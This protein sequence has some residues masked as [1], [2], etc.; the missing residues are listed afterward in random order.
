MAFGTANVLT[1]YGK[2]VSATQVAGTTSTPPKY[3]AIGTGATSAARTAAVGD[4]GLSTEYTAVAR[5]TGVASTVTTLQTNDTFQTVGTI[6]VAGNVAIDEAGLFTVVT[7]S[8]GTMCMSSTFPAV[9]L[10][11]GDSIQITAKIQY[12]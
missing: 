12:T 7:S 8:T 10:L 9:N 1:N 3:I 5:A 2:G 6:T 11:T 4:T